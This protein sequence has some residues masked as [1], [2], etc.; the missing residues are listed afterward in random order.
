MVVGAA[1]GDFGAINSSFMGQSLDSSL[2]F[3]LQEQLL[4]LLNLH[5]IALTMKDIKYL[6]VQ[7][8]LE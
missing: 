3:Y 5:P 6:L 2:G 8:C 4:L 1:N 7:E